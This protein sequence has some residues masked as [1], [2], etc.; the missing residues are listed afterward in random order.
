M[1]DPNDPRLSAVAC[2]CRYY[3]QA[4]QAHDCWLTPLQHPTPTALLAGT[5]VIETVSPF[6]TPASAASCA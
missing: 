5:V 6:T 3:Q 1:T 4:P 2:E